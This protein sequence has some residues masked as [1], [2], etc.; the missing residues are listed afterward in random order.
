MSVDSGAGDEDGDISRSA[1]HNE[2]RWQPSGGPVTA[3]LS[4]P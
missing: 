3:M 4:R 2:V 1:N